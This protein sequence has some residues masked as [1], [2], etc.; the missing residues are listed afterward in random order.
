MASGR[1]SEGDVDRALAYQREHGGF[2]GEALVAC[3]FMSEGEVEWGLA[4]QHDLPYVFPEAETVDYQA[5]SLV[6]PEWA[7]EHLALPIMKTADTLTVIVGSPFSGGPVEELRARTQL[8]IALALASPSKIRE[9]IRE[10]YAR[11]SAA[12]EDAPS[13][14]VDLAR[15]LDTALQ[16]VAPRFGVSVRGTQ[17][18]A[19]WDD[20]GTIRRRALAGNWL[21]ELEAALD[22]APELAVRAQD[23]VFWTARLTRAG[24]VTPVVVG[25]LADESGC[26]YVFQ[27]SRG[28][29]AAERRFAP[30]PAGVVSEVRLL[31]RT[32]KAR[33]VVTTEPRALGHELLPHLPQLLFDPGWRSIYVHSQDRRGEVEAFSFRLPAARDE[34]SGELE[35]LRAFHFD[36]ATV[37]LDVDQPDW[38]GLALDVASVAFVLW[39]DDALEPA[40]QAG[41]R[42]NL[43]VAR[44]SDGGLEWSLQPLQ[45]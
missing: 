5:A 13:R 26:E 21:A 45:A 40:H 20:G 25:F 39:T 8:E 34:W 23:R 43:H 31:A 32:G 35:A 27:P 36:V 44:P 29:A 28:A 30:P 12:D 22:P 2:F 14:P 42:W 41:I 4:S 10:V 7:L 15:A 37:D 24:I 17:A 11:G 38:T 6:A 19:W 16:V 3:G 9:L 1:L 18:W 33:F